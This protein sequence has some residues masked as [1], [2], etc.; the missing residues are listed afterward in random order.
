[1]AKRKGWWSQIQ[2]GEFEKT[3]TYYGSSSALNWRPEHDSSDAER[4]EGP[5]RT[6]V[7]RIRQKPLA[8]PEKKNKPLPIPPI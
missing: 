6:D 7:G 3:K 5:S 8:I 4:S 1:M 2:S